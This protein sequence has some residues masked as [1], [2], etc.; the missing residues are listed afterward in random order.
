[1]GHAAKDTSAETHQTWDRQNG[2]VNL[3]IGT[4]GWS[5]PEWKPAFY[6]A[7]VVQAKFLAY[8]ATRFTACEVNG[9]FYRLPSADTVRRWADA[10]P[11]DFRFSIKAPRAMAQGQV[12]WTDATLRTRDQLLDALTPLGER[13]AVV[14]LRYPDGVARDDDR[15]RTVLDAWEPDAP[16]LVFDFRDSSWFDR[17]VITALAEHGHTIS[18]NETQGTRLDIL[19]NGPLAYVRLRGEHY[20]DVSR[21]AWID[22]ARESAATRPTYL[23]GRHEG[24]PAGDPHAGVGLAAWMVETLSNGS[25][26]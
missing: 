8:Y 14:L 9:T 20:D 24:I 12:R 25:A 23:F 5:Y 2:P 4:S 11:E 19:P 18:V 7:D 10:T 1:M 13:L 22:T 6:P 3:F 17:D 15:L 16:R 26:E 21:R